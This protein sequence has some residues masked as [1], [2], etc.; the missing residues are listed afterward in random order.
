MLSS[1]EPLAFVS[2]S[3]IDS[4]VRTV[5]DSSSVGGGANPAAVNSSDGDVLAKSPCVC[6]LESRLE[7]VGCTISTLSMLEGLCKKAIR[8]EESGS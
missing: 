3:I 4:R 2:L 7:T 8:A 1:F 6:R 5:C